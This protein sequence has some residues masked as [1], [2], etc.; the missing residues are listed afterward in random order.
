MA[1]LIQNAFTQPE[2]VPDNGNRLL[3][4][5][6]YMGIR[7]TLEEHG[8]NQLAAV[9]LAGIYDQVGDGWREP[10]NA[11][12]PLHTVLSVNGEV[13]ALPEKQPSAHMQCLNYR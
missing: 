7:G 6:G 9:N 8:K 12:N 3:I 4:G 2:T 5:N 11:P 10:L 1:W 13:L